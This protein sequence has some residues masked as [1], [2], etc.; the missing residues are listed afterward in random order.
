MM[1]SAADT[2]QSLQQALE[3]SE[4]RVSDYHRLAV[5]RGDQINDLEARLNY[6]EAR[7]RELEKIDHDQRGIIA[8]VYTSIQTHWK[9]KDAVTDMVVQYVNAEALQAMRDERAKHTTEGEVG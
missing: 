5:E 4:A 6:S 8:H 1:I 7:V 3:A 2:I 9:I